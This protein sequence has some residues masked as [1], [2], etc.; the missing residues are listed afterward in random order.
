MW[1]GEQEVTGPWL[2]GAMGWE[3]GDVSDLSCYVGLSYALSRRAAWL[4]G[5]A[6]SAT[7]GSPSWPQP[8][9]R[10]DPQWACPWL[11]GDSWVGDMSV[12]WLVA[13]SMGRTRAWA[14]ARRR[15]RAERR[16]DGNVWGCVLGARSPWEWP[17]PLRGSEEEAGSGPC[18]SPGLLTLC[19]L[20]F[21]FW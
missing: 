16:L 11:H 18:W 17:S 8:A 20:H 19:I 3:V 5:H 4:V 1:E 14:E 7:A 9:S 13:S 2:P 12:S 21:A 6:H 15:D 10:P